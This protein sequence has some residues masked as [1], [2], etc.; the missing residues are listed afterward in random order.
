MVNGV[1]RLVFFGVAATVM[2]VESFTHSMFPIP[3]V[4]TQYARGQRGVIDKIS[5]MAEGLDEPICEKG[6]NHRELP[7]LA[8]FSPHLIQAVIASEDS[9]FDWHIGSEPLSIVRAILSFGKQGASTISQ[10]V[11]RTIYR[12]QVGDERDIGRKA[13]EVFYAH[14][15][16]LFY[17]KDEILK[18]YLN[19]VY[20]GAENYGF[21]AA[22]QSYF[23][24]SA[25]FLKIEEA[26]SLVSIL[27]APNVF[28]YNGD[29]RLINTGG[30]ERQRSADLAGERRSRVIERMA[31]LGLINDREKAEAT[32]AALSIF[33][34]KN[35]TKYYPGISNHFCNY[36]IERDLPSILGSGRTVSGGL[37]VETSL[38]IATQKKAEKI[39]R[40]SVQDRGLT[41]GFSQGAIL[42]Q[43][44]RNGELI[45]MA[46]GIGDNFN[47]VVESY[48]QPGSTFKIFTYIT[49]LEKNTPLN[50]TFSCSP[51]TLGEN[52]YEGC[53]RSG[54]LQSLTIDRG[55]VFSENVISLRLA[56]ELGLEQVVDT[57]C[58]L[59][60]KFEDRI[61][62]ENLQQLEELDRKQKDILADI[63]RLKQEL[64]VKLKQST[65]PKEK[66]ELEKEKNKLQE[67]QSDAEKDYQRDRQ[68]LQKP[69]C[70]FPEAALNPGLVIGQTEARMFDL[71]PVYATI[72]NNGIYNRPHG[73]R[74]IRDA[75]QCTNPNTPS[76]CRVLYDSSANRDKLSTRKFSENTAT[77]LRGILAEA[78][79]SGTGQAAGFSDKEAGKTG[80]TDRGADMWFIGY[81]RSNCL[82]TSVWLGN[83]LKKATKGDSRL[84]ARLWRDYMQGLRK[85]NSCT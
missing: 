6:V 63:D 8:D 33:D 19:R 29:N 28:R 42:S 5:I 53:E 4:S 3:Q 15:I 20:L 25:A 85:P 83:D 84:A 37:I 34:D 43:N 81:S 49:A 80:T 35:A 69:Y 76:T 39:L 1:F 9:R 12:G 62:P 31:S 64:E 58:N 14:A 17:P 45:A 60:I 7:R 24:R 77:Q 18:A 66:R 22:S 36:I 16:E 10:Q 73:I 41:Y 44:F 65:D 75:K 74:R 50:K 55:L 2:S 46:G 13:R 51:L 54:S 32:G 70:A 68:K 59:G 11:A 71:N 23:G 57:A 82:T 47:R 67:R 30:E 27:P 38:D 48:R 78:V 56:K 40:S 72:A 52:K 26:A 79:R 61:P 21:E